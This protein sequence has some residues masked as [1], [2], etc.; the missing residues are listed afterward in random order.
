VRTRNL[1]FLAAAVSLI[2]VPGAS[3][4][5]AAATGD[6]VEAATPE[7]DIADRELIVRFARAYGMALGSADIDARDDALREPDDLDETARQALRQLID[8]SGLGMAEWRG[9]F[10]RMDDDPALRERIDSLAVPFRV[11]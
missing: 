6:A 11:Q 4:P 9:M 7:N 10:A 8:D 3:L 2:A 5:A 1:L